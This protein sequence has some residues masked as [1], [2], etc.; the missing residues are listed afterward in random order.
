MMPGPQKLEPSDAVLLRYLLGAL[1]VDEAEPI[2]EAS[3]VDED[4]AA[5]LNAMECDLVDS[6]VR[7]ELE[8]TNLA[9]F[10]SWY[11]SSPLRARKVEAAKA[12]MLIVDGA[13]PGAV[14]VT[15]GAKAPVAAPA[16]APL[17][18]RAAADTK[19]AVAASRP[20]AAGIAPTL[21]YGVKPAATKSRGFR[22]GIFRAWPMLGFAAAVLILIV[23]VGFLTSRNKRLRNEVAETKKQT[24]EL[25]AKLNEEHAAANGGDQKGGVPANLAHGLD[26]VATVTM[27]LPSPT[28]GASNVPTIKIPAGTGLVVLSLGLGSNNEESYRAQLMDPATQKVLWHSGVLRPGSDGTYVSVTVPAPVLRSKMYLLQLM[29]DAANGGSELLAS[30]PFRAEVK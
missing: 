30:Y 27:F 21:S 29:H 12:I 14:S 20:A 4:L 25:T 6:Y 15:S 24:T 2:E 7:S 5:R 8:G 3:I 10:Q 22:L 1:P 19:P 9:K 23:A 17:P 13:E 16:S 11:L 18:A 28:R 26:N